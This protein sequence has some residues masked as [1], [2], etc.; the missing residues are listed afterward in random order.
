MEADQGWCSG[1]LAFDIR[2]GRIDRVDVSG[3]KVAMA[4]D[5][6]S[7]MLSGKGTGRLYFDPSVTQRQRE[8]LE[9]VLGGKKGGV[10]EA[11][12]GLVPNSLPSKEAAITIQRTRDEA[13]ITVGSYGEVVSKVLRGANGKLTK[14]QNAAAAFREN[15]TLAK[16]TGSRWNDPEMRRWQS[17]GHSEQ[18][19]FNWSA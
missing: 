8:A 14:L 13:R 17:G 19:N 11:V 6:P 3:A 9:A 12:G 5:W 4:I 18:S 2:R 10:S 1:V 16:G 7:G 15:I